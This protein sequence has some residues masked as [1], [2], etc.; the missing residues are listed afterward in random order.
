MVVLAGDRCHQ[1]LVVSGARGRYGLVGPWGAHVHP[2]R[3]LLPVGEDALQPR[4]LALVRPG[5]QRLPF[6]LHPVLRPAGEQRL[7]DKL[8]VDRSRD[9]M[10]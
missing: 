3:D 4:G 1:A 10:L 9:R 7:G 2:W 6:L 5:R 8:A